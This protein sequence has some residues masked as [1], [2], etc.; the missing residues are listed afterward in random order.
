MDDAVRPSKE[1]FDRIYSESY[2]EWSSYLATANENPRLP[3]FSID[4]KPLLEKTP[5][6]LGYGLVSKDT[7]LFFTFIEKESSRGQFGLLISGQSI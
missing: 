5:S 3:P 4:L 7:E 2:G 1:T 6:F